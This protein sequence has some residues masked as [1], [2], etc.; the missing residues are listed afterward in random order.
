MKIFSALLL[1]F[2]CLLSG[3]AAQAAD[4]PPKVRQLATPEYP[5]DLLKTGTP[6]WVVVQVHVRSDGSPVRMEVVDSSNGG[7]ERP[8]LKSLQR[9]IFL[10][11][12]KAGTAVEGN[13]TLRLD[14]DPKTRQ[15]TVGYVEEKAGPAAK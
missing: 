11:A 14:F 8:V 12:R 4:T 13:V 5:A 7:Y 10:P 2:S 9:T 6:G 3:R 1:A 15:V